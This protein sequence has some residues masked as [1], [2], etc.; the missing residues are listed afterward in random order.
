MSPGTRR[1]LLRRIAELKTVCA[2]A[3]QVVGTLADDAGRFSDPAVV[4]ALDNLS[5]MRLQHDDVLP[6]DAAIRGRGE[7][8]ET[9]ATR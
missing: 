3:Y 8:R 2:E 4:K 7:A 9:D 1:K 6:F 5:A